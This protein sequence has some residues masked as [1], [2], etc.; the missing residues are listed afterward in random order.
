M[1]QEGQQVL[2]VMVHTDI[3]VPGYPVGS[4]PLNISLRLKGSAQ[5][6]S[7]LTMVHIYRACFLYNTQCI[8]GPCAINEMG[9]TILILMRTQK[10]R[11]VKKLS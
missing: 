10:L 7:I 4:V 9:L 6:K 2:T 1:T 5:Y 8:I 11:E 3:I